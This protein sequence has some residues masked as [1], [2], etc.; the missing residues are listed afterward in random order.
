MG[1]L[2]K[3]AGCRAYRLFANLLALG[4]RPP[5]NKGWEP[6]APTPLAQYWY[7]SLSV[8]SLQE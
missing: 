8:H 4:A 7:G 2:R 5:L 3:E 6:V 1:W